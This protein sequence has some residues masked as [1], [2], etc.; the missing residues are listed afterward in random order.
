MAIRPDSMTLIRGNLKIE[1]VNL[2]EGYCGDYDINDPEDVNLL[3]FDLSKIVDG[4]WELVDD[5]SYCTLMPA[6]TPEPM[7]EVALEFL[8][9]EFYD[10]VSEGY[11]G[12]KIG[13]R[14]SWI[15]PE[16]IM[17]MKYYR[18]KLENYKDK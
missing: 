15:S 9:D 18:D 7:L 13:E 5:C 11:R 14:L 4:Y 1:W 2:G 3:R 8:M 12:K 16:M 10:E 6:N 17:K